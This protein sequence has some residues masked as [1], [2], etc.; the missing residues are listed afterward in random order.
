MGHPLVPYSS[1]AKPPLART[2]CGSLDV[3][4]SVWQVD[5]A[6]DLVAGLLA[7]LA[8]SGPVVAVDLPGWHAIPHAGWRTR[9]Y[10]RSKIAAERAR[11]E[12]RPAKQAL[13]GIET[14]SATTLAPKLRSDCSE[15]GMVCASSWLLRC[16]GG[17]EAAVATLKPGGF[18]VVLGQTDRDAVDIATLTEPGGPAETVAL[19]FT[20]YLV[21]AAKPVFD[22]AACDTKKSGRSTSQWGIG[23]WSKPAIV[24]GGADA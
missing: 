10:C 21:A 24:G 2:R 13:A 12:I 6:A 8:P 3:P 1:S 9:L 15:A 23:I 22:K 7:E 11:S 5:A 19:D 17:P 20:A 4:L 18:L 16:P 14:A